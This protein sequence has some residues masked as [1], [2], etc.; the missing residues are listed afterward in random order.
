ML[1]TLMAVFWGTMSIMLMLGFGEG[2]K[3]QLTA[4]Q[5]GMGEGIVI[6]WGGQ[7]SIP[8]QGFGRGRRIHLLENDI[9]YLRNTVPGIEM[10]A[11]E[12]IRWGAEIKY[13][14][15]VLSERINGVFPEYRELRHMYAEMG[16]R[17][18]N[19]YDIDGKRRVAYLGDRVKERLFGPDEAV[20]ETIYIRGVPFLVV[21]VMQHKMQMSSYQGRDEDVIVIPASTF[22]AIFGDPYLDDIVYKPVSTDMAP[23]VA[24]GIERMMAIKHK[25]NPDDDRALSTWDVIESQRVFYN[26]FLGIQIFLGIIGA[27]TLLIASVGVANIMYVSIKERTREIGIKMA[28]GGR[29]IYIL[30]Q[31][32]LEALGITFFG[33]FLGISITYIITEVYKR[34]PLESEVL[35]FM[36]KPTISLEIGLIVAVILGIMGILSGFFPALRASSVSPVEALRYE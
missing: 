4:R 16:G 23:T 30:T 27:L 20:G 2:L 12:Y 28:V 1:L 31:F 9:A 19:H 15:K 14:E 11:G 6:L 5:K 22:V 21:G 36:G 29:K 18:I 32:L 8:H 35:D 7:T 24:E 17:M 10:I 13:K 26:I 34:I 25:F 33:G 3:R